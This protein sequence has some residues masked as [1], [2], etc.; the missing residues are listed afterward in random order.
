MKSRWSVAVVTAGLLALSTVTTGAADPSARPVV[1]TTTAAGW[2]SFGQ[3]KV[4]LTETVKPG[5]ISSGEVSAVIAASPAKAKRIAARAA[6]APEVTAADI[7]AYATTP[8]KPGEADR[9]PQPDSDGKVTYA[10]RAGKAQTAAAAANGGLPEYHC[11]GWQH[12]SDNDVHINV[13]TTYVF[14]KKANGHTYFAGKGVG[15]AYATDSGCVD[16]D[17]LEQVAGWSDLSNGIGTV[18]SW[19]P[20]SGGT[21][22]GSCTSVTTSASGKG[23]ETSQTKEVCPEKFGA[24]GPAM[25]N[26]SSG[27]HWRK[28]GA[29]TVPKDDVRGTHF[30]NLN[31]W[32]RSK[33]TLYLASHGKVWWD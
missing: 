6:H 14:K 8:L 11:T 3:V 12:F 10:G 9:G 25:T 26:S 18:F 2:S 21:T 19:S 24:Y 17:R 20:E 5:G 32:N 15:S 1:K 29:D 4:K 31:D 23:F 16:C 22:V 7:E 13:C 28:E 33:G 30:V 27:S